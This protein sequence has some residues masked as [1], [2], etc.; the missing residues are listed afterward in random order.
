MKVDL[1]DICF[2]L[3][4]FDKYYKCQD[5]FIIWIDMISSHG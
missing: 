5:T 1:F 4:D 3:S 2:N